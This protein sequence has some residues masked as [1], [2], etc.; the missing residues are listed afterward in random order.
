MQIPAFLN[1]FL[2]KLF[3]L[4]PMI[5]AFRLKESAVQVQVINGVLCRTQLPAQLNLLKEPHAH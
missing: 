5:T 2:K 1:M 3:Q 4:F